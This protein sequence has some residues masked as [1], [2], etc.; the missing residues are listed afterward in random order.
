[1]NGNPIAFQ[2]YDLWAA[3]EEEQQE[4]KSKKELARLKMHWPAPKVPLP[5]HSESYRSNPID[6]VEFYYISKKQFIK[7]KPVIH[8]EIADHQPNIFSRMKKGKNGR[9]VSRKGVGQIS[10]RKALMRFERYFI[11]QTQNR[12]T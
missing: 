3:E 8:K 2:V 7:L 6:T 5:G 9:K 10:Y 4:Q 1:M 11:F 12:I